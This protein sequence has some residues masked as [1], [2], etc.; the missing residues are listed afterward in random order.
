MTF[1]GLVRSQPT[2]EQERN[3]HDIIIMMFV[4]HIEALKL[5]QVRMVKIEFFLL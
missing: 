4:V 2:N 3:T 1:C 5:T